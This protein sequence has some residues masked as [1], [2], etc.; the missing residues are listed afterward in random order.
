M[1]YSKT[2]N[3]FYSHGIHETMP[4]DTI[5]ISDALYE[6]M[7]EG[8]SNGMV[9]THDINGMPKGERYGI[10]DEVGDQQRAEQAAKDARNADTMK[11]NKIIDRVKTYV[12]SGSII[13]RR[14]YCYCD[15]FNICIMRVSVHGL[16]ITYNSKSKNTLSKIVGSAFD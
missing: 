3:G 9:I 16:Q 8:Q 7:L 10:Q 14:W 11:K 12:M 4:A 2:T 5:E 15:N 6:S 1:L 13:I